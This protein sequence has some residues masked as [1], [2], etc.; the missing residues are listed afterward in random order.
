MLIEG[1]YKLF[2]RSTLNRTY[3]LIKNLVLLLDG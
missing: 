1:E 3:D 2:F